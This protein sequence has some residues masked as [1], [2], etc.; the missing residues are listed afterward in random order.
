MRARTSR[1]G[2]DGQIVRSDANL[3][4]SS[5]DLCAPFAA[6]PVSQYCSPARR[7]LTAFDTCATLVSLTCPLAAVYASNL[8]TSHKV[9]SSS[10]VA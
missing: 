1:K 4:I 8:L 5:P 3:P 6:S 7:P 9:Y 2:I 10:I